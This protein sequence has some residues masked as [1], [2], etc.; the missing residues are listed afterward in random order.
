MGFPSGDDSWTGCRW[1]YALPPLH[2]LPGGKSMYKTISIEPS[3]HHHWKPA[4][5]TLTGL[6]FKRTRMFA[7]GNRVPYYS[8]LIKPIFQ[9]Y[10]QRSKS[11]ENSAHNKTG[12]RKT[13]GVT[14]RASPIGLRCHEHETHTHNVSATAAKLRAT[15]SRQGSFK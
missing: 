9:N 12:T 15:Q 8:C 7:D 2:R 11:T 13:R 4:A 3:Q 5:L 1:V 10:A 6:Y 14:P